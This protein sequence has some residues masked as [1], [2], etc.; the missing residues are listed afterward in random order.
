[1]DA[2][3]EEYK[4][5]LALKRNGALLNNLG[6]SHYLKGEYEKAFTA[7]SEALQM[8]PN[9]PRIYNNLALVL[10]QM[11][12]YPEALQAFKSG[13]DEASAYHNLGRVYARKGKYPE[14]LAAFEKALELKPEFY[15]SAYENKKRMQAALPLIQQK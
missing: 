12:R 3:I 4:T 14:A 8:E 9:S 15:V 7:F 2:A 10:C 5:A 6:L 11:G 1:L 13:G